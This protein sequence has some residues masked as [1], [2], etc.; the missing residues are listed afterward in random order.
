MIL[1]GLRLLVALLTFAAGTAAARLLGSSPS[2]NCK[3]AAVLRGAPAVTEVSVTDYAPKSRSCPL[4]RPVRVVQGGTLDFKAVSKP[5]AL[6]P[7]AAKSAGVEGVVLV[8]V[9]VDER[10][11]VLSA[12]AKDGPAQLRGAAESAAREARFRPTLLSGRPV[13]V[14]GDVTYDF[15]LR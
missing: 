14:E 2:G 10:G 3:P 15:R 12:E 9:S 7:P 4:D 6:Y 1:Y 13:K 11:E 5:P 8:R